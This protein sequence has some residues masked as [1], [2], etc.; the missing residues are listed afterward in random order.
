MSDKPAD[1]RAPEPRYQGLPTDR[2][3]MGET[4]STIGDCKRA[5]ECVNRANENCNKRIEVMGTSCDEVVEGLKASDDM[6]HECG[7]LLAGRKYNELFTHLSKLSDKLGELLRLAAAEPR[8]GDDGMGNSDS[9]V[10]SG[11]TDSVQ[12]FRALTVDEQKNLRGVYAKLFHKVADRPAASQGA[13]VNAAVVLDADF[14]TGSLH[15]TDQGAWSGMMAKL[16]NE[17]LAAS[18]PPQDVLELARG[19]ASMMI[20]GYENEQ[21]GKYPPNGHIHRC[22]SCY[23]KALEVRAALTH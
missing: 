17:Y 22:Q 18:Q 16:I 13:R 2:E 8:E 12:W 11:A 23:E 5:M 7:V 9:S 21:Q 4:F 19:L 14:K 10:D 3:F 1:Q 15:M 20:V 6:V